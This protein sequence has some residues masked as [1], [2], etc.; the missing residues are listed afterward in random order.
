MR[1]IIG[2]ILIGILGM[3]TT[4]CNS[5]KNTNLSK[6]EFL[7]DS[8]YS[9]YLS[10]YRKHNVYL[11]KGF[12]NENDYPI[13]YAT[14]GNSSLTEKKNLLDSLI[15][16]KIIKP[17]IFIAS[18]SNNKIADSTSTTTGDG[19]KV[20][21]SYRNFEYVDRKPT[22]LEDSLLVDRFQNHKL[23]FTKELINKV[24][25]KYNQKVSRAD[26]YFYGVSNSAG[27]GLS[28]LN[29]NPDIIGTYI[30]FSTFGG[31]IQSN[32]WNENTTYPNLYLRYGSDEFFGLK[33][34]AEFLKIKY[35]ES[36]SFIETKEYEGGH[37]NEFWKKEFSEIIIRILK[38]E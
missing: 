26:R 31:D 21:L 30:C 24:E 19:K 34:D 37:N 8:I 32:T 15:D 7:T 5:P 22:R 14:D 29:N 36:N 1:I 4:S 16:N 12:D 11:P 25:K 28:L 35:A 10:E 38:E 2:T 27:F 17:L 18:F 3:L 23:Y 20:K 6:S 9:E 13:I 33:E